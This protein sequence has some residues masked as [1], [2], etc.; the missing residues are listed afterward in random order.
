[1]LVVFKGV[2]VEITGIE[3]EVSEGA[4]ATEAYYVDTSEALDDV[5]L[6]QLTEYYAAKIYDAWYETQVMRAEAYYEGDR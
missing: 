3:G 1:M 4:Q 6:D 2:E 5:E